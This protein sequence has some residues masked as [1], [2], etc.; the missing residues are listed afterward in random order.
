[1]GRH[2]ADKKTPAPASSRYKHDRVRVSLDLTRDLYLKLSRLVKDG[3]FRSMVKL[4]ETACWWFIIKE[5]DPV[6]YVFVREILKLQAKEGAAH[7]KMDV[8]TVEKP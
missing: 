3:R 5:K 8:E 6:E 4:I 2:L 7:A 1:M